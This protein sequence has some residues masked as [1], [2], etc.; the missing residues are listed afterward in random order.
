MST[1]YPINVLKYLENH[2][3]IFFNGGFIIISTVVT[4]T[5]FAYES[6]YLI[7]NYL[8]LLDDTFS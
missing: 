7:Q 2:L 4:K 5:G 8:G 6:Q 3:R 1:M